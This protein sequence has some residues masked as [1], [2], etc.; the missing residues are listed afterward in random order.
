M[1]TT[2]RSLRQQQRE[3]SA[4]LR[5]KQY[6]WVQVAAEFCARYGVNIRAALRMA[7]DWSQRDVAEQWN[8]R[9]PA[10]PKTFKNFSYWELWPGPTGHAPSLDVLARLAEL[11]ECCVADLVSDCPD[12][13]DS[14]N[15]YRDARQLSGIPS[16]IGRASSSGN[17]L[18]PT[19]ETMHSS[20]ALY[21]LASRLEEMDVHELA[22][23]TFAWASH[24]GTGL[25]RRALLLKVSTAISLAAASPAFA[26]ESDGASLVTSATLEGDLS[27]IWHSHYAY[28]STGR[29]RDFVGEHYLAMRHKGDRFLGESVPASNGSRLRLD[30]VL[31]GSIATGTWS[32][33]T[34]PTGYYR[35]SVYHG[36]MQLVIDP[37][38]K[39]MKGKWIGFD[40]ESFV[41]S[42]N[43]ELNWVEEERSR[44]TRRDYHFKT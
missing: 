23:L 42:D 3:L 16:A 41:Q 22:R 44:S 15:V 6:T 7:H 31:N 35:G 5:E 43:W 24:A 4:E 36:A 1:P 18:Y 9:W 11:Y 27:G 26:E 40:R 33:R 2:S 25:N 39:T 14:D 21:A 28:T 38:G 20:P 37:M 17:E 10:D 8:L 12:F 13:R 19:S 30:L 34:S 29:G 32:E